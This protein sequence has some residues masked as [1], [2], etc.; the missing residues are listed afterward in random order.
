[1]DALAAWILLPLVLVVASW[2][3][4]L[5]VER[6]F[7]SELDGGLVI[8]VG[9]AGT[10]AIL[11]VPYRIGF[12]AA[13]AT[14]VLGIA[15]ALGLWLGRDRL[16]ASLPGP[17]VALGGL[18][19]YLVYIAPVA[20]TAGATFAGYTFLGDNAVH[21][22]LVD[23]VQDHGS[24]MGTIPQDSFGAVLGLNLGNGYPLGPHFQLA[25][26]TTLLGTDVAWLYQGYIAAVAALTV[27]PAARL[28]AALGI[29]ERACAAGAAVAAAAYLPYSYGLQG[30]AKE[31]IMIMLVVLGA[32][33]AVEL[34]AATRPLKPALMFAVPVVGAFSVYSAGGLP[35]LGL[36]ALVAIAVAVINSPERG[37]TL[38]AAAG[39][40]VAVFALGAAVSIA[41]A[42]D[43]FAP[44]RRLLGSTSD[45][46]IGN[47]VDGL[48]PWEAFGIWLTGD[49]RFDTSRHLIA[50]PL[51]LLAAALTIAGVVF[52]V[53]RR[54][55]GLLYAA[56][57]ALAVWLIVPAGIYI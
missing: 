10:M 8:P 3:T 33:L 23:H 6:L 39:A 48:P 1:M 51:I 49:F 41:S 21:F 45:A 31:L 27:I 38:L 36:M 11:S 15:V 34:A 2:G 44:A 22:V 42:L 55:L 47:L 37:R 28:L 54:A 46:G 24:P 7:R 56:G 29:G 13:V 32:V 25:S 9:F 57:A 4:G 16:R 17:A 26:L 30:G 40:L 20:L 19:A 14:P 18:A 52:A 43:F 5:L 35:W 53:R 12:G 50:Y